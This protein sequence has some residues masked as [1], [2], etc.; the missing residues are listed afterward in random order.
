MLARAVH[1]LLVSRGGTY[2]LAGSLAVAVGIKISQARPGGANKVCEM[3]VTASPGGACCWSVGDLQCWPCAAG[4]PN[5][6]CPVQ[7]IEAG[8]CTG[9]VL[10]DNHGG[11]IES[12]SCLASDCD[13]SGN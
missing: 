3:R 4:N 13:H 6:P 11:C 12:Y 9:L 5:A 8:N 7:I 10:V 2:L 1:R